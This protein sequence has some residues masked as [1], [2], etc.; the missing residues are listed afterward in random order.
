VVKA[1]ARDGLTF[2]GR[3]LT[4]ARAGELYWKPL[5]HDH[6]L[7]VLHNPR[8]AGAFCYGRRRHGSDTDGHQRTFVK[9]AAEWTT[10]IPSARPGFISWEQFQANQAG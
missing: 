6:V 10:L 7:F 3:H 8:Y 5:R 9:P 2:P 4:V 1:F